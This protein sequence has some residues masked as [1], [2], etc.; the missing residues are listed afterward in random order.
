MKEFIPI[1]FIW[2]IVCYAATIIIF[3]SNIWGILIIISMLLSL[4]TTTYISQKSR[5]EELDKK[6]DKLLDRN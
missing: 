1:F 4:L 6:I 3:E 2:L 5:I